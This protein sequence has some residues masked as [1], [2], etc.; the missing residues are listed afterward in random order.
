MHMLFQRSAQSQ[1]HLRQLLWASVLVACEN[2]RIIP[3]HQARRD[4]VL[5]RTDAPL[6]PSRAYQRHPQLRSPRQGDRE[7]AQRALV[8]ITARVLILADHSDFL[9]SIS[10]DETHMLME[11]SDGG[12][13]KVLLPS[14]CPSIYLQLQPLISPLPLLS[15][16]NS[17]VLDAFVEIIGNAVD[18]STIKFLACINMGPKLGASPI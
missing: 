2:T 11:A 10:N 17:T 6:L 5:R 15:L 14:V 9:R 7:G 4:G 16:H 1:K 13:M 12:Q 8:L 3:T 18:A